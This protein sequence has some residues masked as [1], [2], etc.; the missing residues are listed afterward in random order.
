M[1]DKKT[2]TVGLELEVWRQLKQMS[3]DRDATLSETVEFLMKRLQE[4]GKENENHSS[5]GP[6]K[7]AN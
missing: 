2:K 5:D 4:Q 3:L 7:S 1:A 6:D